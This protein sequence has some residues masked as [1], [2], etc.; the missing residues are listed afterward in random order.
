MPLS[1]PIIKCSG[2]P[3]DVGRQHGEAAKHQIAGSIDAYKTLFK[4]MAG[5]DWP[6][7]LE[8]AADFEAKLLPNFLEE[9]E[10]VAEGAGVPLLHI[11]ALNCRS[12]IALTAP[13]DGCTA[14]SLRTKNGVQWL[15]QNWDWKPSVLDSLIILD[16]APY[17]SRPGMKFVTEAGIIGKIGFN[18]FGVGVTLNAIRAPS[19]DRSLLP[20]HLFLRLLLTQPSVS[21]ALDI[22]STLPGIA[23]TCHIL[24][25]DPKTAVGLECSPHGFAFLKPGETS[26]VLSHTNHFLD[27]KIR[28]SNNAVLL[29]QDSP[30]RLELVDAR[31]SSL[32]K[33]GNKVAASSLR[34]ILSDRSLGSV[35]ICRHDSA[36]KNGSDTLFSISMNL[37]SKEAEV[38]CGKPDEAGDLIKFSFQT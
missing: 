33:S 34:N 7:A 36:T 19:L 20:L 26:G 29:W 23:S 30:A 4:E 24:V 38:K 2:T 14:F 11:V 12:E 5:L 15:S 3:K 10:G 27:E 28:D 32:V 21:T 1:F 22:I 16:I 18:S 6:Q 25:A 31:A 17:E 8:I 9:L 35:G 37:S 13:L